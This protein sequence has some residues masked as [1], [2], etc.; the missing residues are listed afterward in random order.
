MIAFGLVLWLVAAVTVY[1]NRDVPMR[2]IAGPLWL[3]YV[4]LLIVV[5]YDLVQAGVRQWWERRRG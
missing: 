1:A 4:A 5:G 2:S 3:A